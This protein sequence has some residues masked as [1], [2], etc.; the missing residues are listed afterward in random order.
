MIRSMKEPRS[1]QREHVW[2][3]KNSSFITM[4]RSMKEPRSDQREH[5]W[6][7]KNSRFI[8]MVQYV[9]GVNH[10]RSQSINQSNKL[11]LVQVFEV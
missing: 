6:F 10:N 3:G 8:T 5:V 1:D 11:H 7:G 4:I 9:C 2:F